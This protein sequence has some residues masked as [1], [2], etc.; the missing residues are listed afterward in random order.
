[1]PKYLIHANYVGEGINGLMKEGGSSRRDAV[2]KLLESMG[3]NLESFYYAF[4]DTD[5]YLVV[6]LPNNV[7][8]SAVLLTVNS[9]GVVACKT[10]VLISPEEVDE[11]TKMTP[12]YRAPGQ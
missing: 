3:G 10:T 4:G 1:M 5:A 12:N 2:K 7:T 8:A 9:S 6:D 11:A